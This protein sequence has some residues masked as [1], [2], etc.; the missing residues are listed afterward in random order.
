MPTSF[1]V[2]KQL[3]DGR[4]HSGEGLAQALS[5]SRASV[6]KAVETLRAR[7]LDVQAVSGKGYR[8]ARPVELLDRE[9]IQQALW[10]EYRDR[11]CIEI[12]QQLASTNAYLLEQA[13]AGAEGNTVCLTE[14]QSAG[15]GRRGR[16]WVSPLGANLYLS[17]LLRLQMSPQAIA[18]FSLVCGIA[19]A[20]AMQELGIDG[21][22]LKWPN[23][24]V[25]QGRKLAGILLEMSG[26]AYGEQRL[27]IG[28]GI[29]VAMPEEN[30]QA[31]DQP[32]VDLSR[33]QGEAVSRNTLAAALLNHLCLHLETYQL[34]GMAPYIDQWM[35]LDSYMGKQVEL[36]SA[37]TSIKGEVCGIDEH[38]S[39]LLKTDDGIHAYQSGEVSLRGR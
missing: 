17:L 37:T 27:I 4:F 12:H 13:R 30:G 35:E 3:Q 22:G 1:E 25:W 5:I 28:I 24:L 10:P 6:W 21:V 8:L 19:L 20:R 38:G 18:G 36:L 23:D 16:Q 2:L 7:G 14:Y 9:A 31:I 15:R 32:W 26:E 33:I 29:N 11:F 39:L 34:E